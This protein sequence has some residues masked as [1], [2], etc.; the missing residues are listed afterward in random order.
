MDPALSYNK[1]RFPISRSHRGLCF[2][3]KQGRGQLLSSTEKVWLVPAG[4]MFSA[5]RSAPVQK[6]PSVGSCISH[7]QMN[8][9][10][11]MDT[12]KEPLWSSPSADALSECARVCTLRELWFQQPSR[13]QP[14]T[15]PPPWQPPCTHLPSPGCVQH[16]SHRQ[17]TCTLA[18][19]TSGNI[20]LPT[21]MLMLITSGGAFNT[22]GI[23]NPRYLK[24]LWFL[25]Q[26]SHGRWPV[27][28]LEH[29]LTF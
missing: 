17:H 9:A 23:I 4:E 12:A 18:V 22:E 7:L 26:S 28:F 20:Y 27:G 1:W 25:L 14:G 11:A 3:S 19:F 16:Y 10:V 5:G 6:S 29:L 2:R 24:C 21:V 15:S 13:A 8:C